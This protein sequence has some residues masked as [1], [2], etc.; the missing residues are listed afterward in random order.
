MRYL[1]DMDGVINKF[2]KYMATELVKRSKGL[3]YIDNSGGYDMSLWF[4]DPYREFWDIFNTILN[5]YKFWT[6]IPVITDSLEWLKENSNK[7]I[8]LCTK[9]YPSVNCL[10]GKQQWIETYLPKYRNKVIYIQDK[11]FLA[12]PD[13]ILVDDAISNVKSFVDAGGSARLF[14]KEYNKKE[15]FTKVRHLSELKI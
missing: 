5:D 3:H 1:I 6:D 2:S 9:P 12:K 7:E 15:S 13:T 10:S 4:D 11:S 14:I 8:Y